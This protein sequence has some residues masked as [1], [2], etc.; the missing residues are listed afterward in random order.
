MKVTKAWFTQNLAL[1][2]IALVLAI[3]TWLYLNDEILKSL[4]TFPK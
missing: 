3:F 4:F 2:V 1:K